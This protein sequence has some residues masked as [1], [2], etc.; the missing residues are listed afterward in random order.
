VKCT[1]RAYG[2]ARHADLVFILP[3]VLSKLNDE[4]QQLTRQRQFQCP[5]VKT[6]LSGMP[7]KCE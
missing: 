2:L 3:I 4:K 6:L 5:V 7:T 1:L